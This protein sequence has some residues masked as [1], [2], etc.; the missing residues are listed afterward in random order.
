MRSG[1]LTHLGPASEKMRTE[2]KEFATAAW[3]GKEIDV[4]L[5][6]NGT[7]ALHLALLAA[8]VEPN[9]E[10]II[11]NFSYVAVANSVLYC[12]AKIVL[13]DINPED[14]NLNLS[15][16]QN[17]ISPKT[18]AIILVDNYGRNFKFE[19]SRPEYLK[20]IRII[21][22]ISE[23]FPCNKG[24]FY[25]DFDFATVSFFANKIIT[26]GEGGAIFANRDFIQ[27][28]RILKNQGVKEKGT[29]NHEVLGYNYRITNLAAAIFT[30]QWSQRDRI[31][32]KRRKM[33]DCYKNEFLKLKID[34]ESNNNNSSAPWLF[35]VK[36][37]HVN[38][39]KLSDIQQ[40]LKNSKIET[41]TGFKLFDQIKYLQE[42]IAKKSKT[43]FSNEL[44]VSIIS[45]PTYIGLK[46]KQIRRI[47]KLI[48]SEMEK[49]S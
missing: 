13:A 1:W 30:S 45:L 42:E 40:L 5:T 14:W 6:S 7:V 31:I 2:L 12:G 19:G 18:K 16:V 15:D 20:D 49:T 24:N 37:L 43:K 21:R 32:R 3:E 27:K 25:N 9:D 4:A 23:S 26:T 48:K 38:Q 33:F 10:V 47:C 28:I 46:K 22:D 11:P 41:R 36:L 17:L 34:Y 29:F 39:K 44:A 35:T 8:G